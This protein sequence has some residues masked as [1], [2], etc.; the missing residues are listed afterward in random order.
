MGLIAARL[1]SAKASATK[2]M[3]RCAAELRRAGRDV[4]ILSQG[5]LDFE[6]PQAIRAAGIQAIESGHTRYTPVPGTIELR[7]AIATKL[8]V[9]YGATYEIDQITVGGGAKQVIFNAL[10]ATLD[11]GDHVVVPAPC[12]VSYPEMVRLAGGEPVIVRCAEERGFKLTPLDLEAAI[13]PCTKWLML[14]SPSN[15]TGAVYTAGELL[16]IA[17]VL[18]RH[19]HVWLLSDDIYEKLVY[20]DT[21]FAAMVRVA[22]DLAPRCLV[23]NGVSKTNAMTG[24]RIGYGA[25]DNDLIKAMNVIQGQ[26]T[27][28]A[29]SISQCAAVAALTGDQPYVEEFRQELERRRDLVVD[30]L[31]SV[32]GLRCSPPDG[33]FYVFVNCEGL[34]GRHAADGRELGTD[35]DVAL[36][37]LDHGVAVVPGEGFLASPYFRVSFAAS[38]TELVAA[39]DR[40]AAA[41]NAL[42]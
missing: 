21:E 30:R 41:C 38:H 18:R 25:G 9:D 27:S 8:R 28:H 17:E 23:V 29:S 40:I 12:W 10:F 22:P 42:D 36:Y 13:S 16:A 31:G 14:N 4:I 32:P 5:E 33:A 19:P 39:C 35:L 34:L 1:S 20:D 6:T 3:T 15:P 2:E 11:P 26:T 24:W 7:T 37:L